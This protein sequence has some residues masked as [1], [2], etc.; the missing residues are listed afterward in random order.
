MTQEEIKKAVKEA[1][2]ESVAQFYADR[3]QHYQDHQFVRD[4]RDLFVN[5]RSTAT[6]TFIGIFITGIISLVVLGFIFWGRNHI[7]K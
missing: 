7:G 3:E 4:L 6:K 5:I 2:Q 1:L